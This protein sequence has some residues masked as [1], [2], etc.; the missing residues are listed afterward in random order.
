VGTAAEVLY[1]QYET[2]INKFAGNTVGNHRC[3]LGP[4][5]VS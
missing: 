4:V 2:L 1:R 3:P 5:E